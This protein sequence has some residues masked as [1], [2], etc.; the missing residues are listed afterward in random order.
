MNRINR[1]SGFT[2]IELFIWI[3]IA[4]ILLTVV[5]GVVSGFA[6]TSDGKRIGTITK[7]SYKGVFVKSYEGEL[8]M[9]GVRN[10]TD[11]EGHSSMV[12]NVWE[13]SCSNPTIAKQLDD[14]L[15]KE[16]VIKYHQSFPGLSRNTSYDVVSVELVK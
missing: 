10:H 4:L 7:F 13:F 6:G 5:A 15:G 16:V 12:A 1:K 3:T 11:S 9:G 14:L 8:N 2:L